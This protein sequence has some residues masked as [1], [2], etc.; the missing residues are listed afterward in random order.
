MYKTEVYQTP[1]ARV[2][3]IPNIWDVAS[4]LIIFSVFGILAWGASQMSLPYQL[5]QPIPIS[6]SPWALP[7]Y[8]V[9]TVLR[10]FIALACSLTFTLT[11]APLA[12]KNRQAEKLIIPIIDILQSVPI[13]G[14]LSI[15]VVWFIAAFPNSL[16]GP[17]CAAIFAIFT[18]QVWNMT[19]SFYQSLRTL[20][21]EFHDTASVFHL[22]PWQKYWRIEVPYAVPSLL[23]NTMI[24]MSAGWFF[25]V[26]SEAIS[27][28]NQHIMLPGIGSYISVAIMDADLIAIIY[29]IITMLIV[30]LLY[31][32]LLFRPLLAWAEKFKIE[33]NEENLLSQ[34]WFYNLLA[35]SGWLKYS[36]KYFDIVLD[37]CLSPSKKLQKQTQK[38]HFPTF[39]PRV[40]YIAILCWNGFLILTTMIASL[41]LAKFI[42]ETVSWAEI[43]KAFGL[44]LITGCKVAVLTLLASILWIPIGVWIGLNP[45]YIPICQPIIQ[46]IAAFPINLIYPIA[47]TLIVFFELNVQIWTAPLMIL[48][49][50]WYILF[51][52][53][54]GAS[55]IPKELRLVT[56]NFGV[57]R[58]L[59]WKRL[60]LPAIFPYY[61]TGAMTAAAGCWNTSIVAEV[62]SWGDH[63]L[64]AT[65]IGSYITTYT[66]TGDFQRIALGIAVICTYVLLINR[67]I[68]Y[69]LYQKAS[70]R[71]VLE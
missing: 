34:S 20:P 68:W 46:F 7:A 50:Q 38:Y 49:T 58:W 5:G 47:V 64:I 63:T 69:R 3:V 40:S 29:A 23:W 45:R 54:A 57:K 48:G 71:F 61:I 9:N 52:V 19:L 36:K 62:L 70:T 44:G 30:I 13:L 15:T 18:S 67:F 37:Y 51:N 33:S 32:Q 41:F 6:L 28:S 66:K 25:V 65:G 8:A 39:N 4:F 14:F 24:S 11:I 27:V 17:E 12:A 22:S 35:K 55:A 43:Q 56:Q 21:Q 60:I 16:F 10:M 26:A 1:K 59:L 42:L 2:S 31:D 53:I